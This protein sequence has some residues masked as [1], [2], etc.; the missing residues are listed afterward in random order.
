MTL[1]E[2]LVIGIMAGVIVCSL[3]NELLRWTP[4]SHDVLTALLT[5]VLLDL[6]V[7]GRHAFDLAATRAGEVGAPHACPCVALAF[8]GVLAVLH[9]I[10]EE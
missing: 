3:L 1:G 2:M 4:S 10:R 6:A 5:A 8:I 9:V 7:N